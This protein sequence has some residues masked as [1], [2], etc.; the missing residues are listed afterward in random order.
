MALLLV[1]APRVHTALTANLALQLPPTQNRREPQSS[2]SRPIFGSAA[3][4][5]TH[6][7]CEGSLPAVTQS[8]GSAS[9]KAWI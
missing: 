8:D 7:N 2:F 5:S 6:L 1:L 4:E 9:Q 3:P